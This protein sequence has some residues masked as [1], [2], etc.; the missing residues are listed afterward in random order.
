[1]DEEQLGVGA[2]DLNAG[3][4]HPCTPSGPLISP[5]YPS[6]AIS[7]ISK[8]VIAITAATMNAIVQ[9]RNAERLLSSTS[10]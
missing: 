5:H 1:M 7:C 2:D 10:Q 4:G 6:Y 9:P 8:I 3:A